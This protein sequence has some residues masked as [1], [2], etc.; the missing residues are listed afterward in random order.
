MTHHQPNDRQGAMAEEVHEHVA[1]CWWNEPTCN[2][3]LHTH[4]RNKCGGAEVCTKT[5]HE[6]GEGCSIPRLICPKPPQPKKTY[7]PDGW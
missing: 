2:I 3:T 6:H 7:S 5:E 1:G 4:K